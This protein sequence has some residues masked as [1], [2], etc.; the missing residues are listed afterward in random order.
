MK[1]FFVAAVLASMVAASAAPPAEAAR[2]VV[3]PGP[4]SYRLTRPQL[5][6]LLELVKYSA[7]APSDPR[8]YSLEV[9]PHSLRYFAKPAV[10]GAVDVTRIYLSADRVRYSISDTGIVDNNVDWKGRVISINRPN[11]K[12]K[13]QRELEFWADFL[14]KS[15]K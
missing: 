1:R 2:D 10:G 7:A 3:V 15:R 13:L 12:K 6:T 14:K 4:G 8:Y 5:A 9:G 11:P